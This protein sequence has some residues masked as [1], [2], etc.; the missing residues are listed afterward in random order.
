[1]IVGQSSASASVNFQ[2]TP[3]EKN[4]TVN[5]GMLQ[6]LHHRMHLV[7]TFGNVAVV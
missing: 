7:V 6:Y 2:D 5:S 1:M 4:E 3:E